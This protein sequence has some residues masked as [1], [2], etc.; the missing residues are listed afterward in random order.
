LLKHASRFDHV[1]IDGIWNY[2]SFATWRALRAS[3]VP[4]SVY[5]HGMLDPWF[6]DTYPIKHIKK[7]FYWMLAERL[8]FRD[9]QHVIFTA[10]EELQRAHRAFWP[11]AANEVVA[12]LGVPSPEGNPDS[13]QEMFFRC[14]PELRG[15]RLVLYLGRLHPKKGPD[16]LIKSFGQLVSSV[17]LAERQT[18]HLVIAGPPAGVGVAESYGAELADL[19]LRYCPAGSVTFTGM[20]E[21][22]IKWGAYHACSAFVLPSHQEN[23]GMA[24]AEALACGKPVLIS[25]RVNI[26]REILADGA[27][28]ADE[29]SEAGTLALLQGLQRASEDERQVMGAN[30]LGCFKKRFEVRHATSQ[31]LGLLSRA[32][33][34]PHHAFLPARC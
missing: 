30:A 26:W 23:F 17:P 24:V 18:W 10:E 15:K 1:I 20:L 6:R 25:K 3:G 21:G 29:N 11:Y 8:V 34:E 16:L 14:W 4:Y 22:E 7:C 19:A 13:L 9:A 2:T 12:P 27:G 33:T 32:G 28:L 31:L 5:P